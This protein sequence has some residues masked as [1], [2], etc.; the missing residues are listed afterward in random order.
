MRFPTTATHP[1]LTALLLPC[2]FCGGAA[3]L[4]PDPWQD[5]SAR[6]AC[7]GADCAV[8][9]RTEYLLLRFADELVAGWNGRAAP[10]PTWSHAKH[11]SG[12]DD[13]ASAP[14]FPVHAS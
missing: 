1:A 12:T 7:A 14:P 6:I 3:R 4:E 13:I 5:A 11:E 9:P 2:P 10:S 8:R